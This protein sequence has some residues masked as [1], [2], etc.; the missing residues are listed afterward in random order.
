MKPRFAHPDLFAVAQ[1]RHPEA[2]DLARIKRDIGIKRGERTARR[3]DADWMDRALE[4]VR[5]F[6]L[7]HDE[8]FLA[9]NVRDDSAHDG[10]AWGAIFCKAARKGWIEKVGYAPSASSNLSPKVLWKSLIFTGEAA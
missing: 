2:P 4:R 8:P 1:T 6:A 10:R 9:E 7:I 3:V 5:Q